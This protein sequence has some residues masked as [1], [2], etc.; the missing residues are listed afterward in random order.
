MQNDAPFDPCRHWLGIDAVELVTPHRV[1]GVS[2]LETDPLVIV[3]AADQKLGVLRSIDPGPL[4]K[5]RDALITRVEQARDAMLAVVSSG[6]GI[7]APFPSAPQAVGPTFPGV[8]RE[9]S[10]PAVFPAPGFPTAGPVISQPR[11]IVRPSRPSPALPMAV[12]TVLLGVAGWLGYQV[13][14]QKPATSSKQVAKQVALSKAKSPDHPAAEPRPRPQPTPEPKPVPASQPQPEPQPVKP[15]PEPEPEPVKAEPEPEPEPVK[16]EPEPEPEEF[17]ARDRK[18]LETHL[19]DAHA[20]LRAGDFPKADKL[21]AEARTV[22]AKD[23]ASAE[24]V[25]RWDRLAMYARKF[26]DLRDQALKASG[27]NDIELDGGRVIGIVEIDDTRV[28]YRER[29]KTE[30]VR[31]DRLPDDI[32]LAIVQQW[33]NGAAQPGNHIYL[34][35]FHLLRK[36]PDLASARGEWQLAAFGGEQE[37]TAL[38]PLLTDP[39]IKGGH[40]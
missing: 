15:E 5:A 21:L 30:R 22:A 17:T 19:K 23:E 33:F 29:G 38:Q 4:A 12:A 9:P 10:P 26:A 25:D 27:N 20:A 13:F 31:R 40:Q 32:L 16:A 8:S 14:Q 18:T 3:R 37:G 24:R 36:E 39:I 34:G 6:G 2:P 1:L 11:R 35:A 28:V 7:N